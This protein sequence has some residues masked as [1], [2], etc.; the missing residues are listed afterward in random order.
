[1]S[2]LRGRAVLL[3]GAAGG[4]GRAAASL[5][6][7]EGVRL[8]LAGRREEPLRDLASEIAGLGGE[9][10][11][12]P[13]DVRSEADAARAVAA[14]VERF[15]G[16]DALVNNAGVGLLRPFDRLADADFSLQWET[17]V[18][19]A[20]RMTRAALPGL[21]ARRGIVLNVASMA[22]RV[23]APGYAAYGAS[24]F[25][26]VGL[27][28]VLRRELAP[29]GVRVVTLL[30]AAVEG[31]FLDRLPRGAALGRGPAG[32]VLAAAEVARGI[33]DGLR[34]PR[35]QIYLPW[36]NRWF[37]ACNVALPGF[38]DRVLRSLYRAGGPA[39]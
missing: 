23:G 19:G 35:P 5:L 7:R 1:M 13:C 4:I 24:K 14:A 17:N 6:A 10:V 15:G 3:T 2:G 16:L 21:L 22:G 27:G 9:A 34:H 31:E 33:A 26:L 36:W 11:A 32:V 37:A 30:P 29:R 18:A 38:S 39:A 20:A 25:G 12:V 8:A 28:E